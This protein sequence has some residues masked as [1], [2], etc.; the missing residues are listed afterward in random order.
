MD[1]TALLLDT[2]AFQGKNALA[3]LRAGCRDS[4]SLVVDGRDGL[5]GVAAK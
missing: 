2:A 5:V 1:I 3:G 4:D